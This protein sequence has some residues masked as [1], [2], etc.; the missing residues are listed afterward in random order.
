MTACTRSGCSS[1][2]RYR[3]TGGRD[4]I[5]GDLHAFVDESCRKGQYLVTAVIVASGDV[6]R[7]AQDVRRV[8]PPGQR[9][10]HFSAERPSGRR[11]ILDRYCRLA[12]EAQVAVAE[13]LGGND[14]TARELCLSA[15]SEKFSLR[16]VKAVV[17]D[18]RGPDRDRIDRR[19][20]AHLEKRGLVDPMFTYTHRSSRDEILLGLPDAIGWAYGAGGQWR[21]Q[22]EPLVEL[23]T[24]T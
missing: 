14:Q 6:H 10:T 18:S 20:F 15:L 24:I 3:Q 5:L 4:G 11:Q 21:Q 13:Y 8:L 16:G 12:V 23:V 19:L 22:V 2:L 17:L 9:R 1:G 7:V